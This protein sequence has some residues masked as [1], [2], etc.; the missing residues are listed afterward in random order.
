M[1]MIRKRG[2][3]FVETDIDGERVV[4]SLDSGEFFALKDTG[5]A[6][7][8]MLESPLDRAGLLE[9]LTRHY[10][11]AEQELAADLDAFLAQLL[12]AGLVEQA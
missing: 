3:S 2:G 8:Q 9:R 4:M 1:M 11:V 7:W 10:G 12:E 6:I 5:L